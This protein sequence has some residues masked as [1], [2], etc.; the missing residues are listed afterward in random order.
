MMSSFIIKVKYFPGNYFSFY[1]SIKQ[2]SYWTFMKYR[3]CLL[4]GVQ[5]STKNK[6]HVIVIRKSKNQLFLDKCISDLTGMNFDVR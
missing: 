5:R 2:G 3:M 6:I 4:L 1:A